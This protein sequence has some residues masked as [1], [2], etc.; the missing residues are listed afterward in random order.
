MV[1][2]GDSVLFGGGVNNNGHSNLV[3]VYQLNADVDVFAKE[4][5][6]AGIKASDVATS[7]V[8]LSESEYVA[9]KEFEAWKKVS[10]IA[11]GDNKIIVRCFKD[12]PD[13][14]LKI[15]LKV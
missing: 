8:I 13:I 5:A 1:S 12:A 10:H 11:T 2:V 6:C 9:A 4:I 15:K 7:D 3:D 14:D